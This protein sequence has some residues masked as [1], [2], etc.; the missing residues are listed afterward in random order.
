M[1]NLIKRHP[2]LAYSLF[3]F[4]V[5]WPIY[6]LLVAVRHGWMDAPIPYW[7]HYLASFGPTVGALVVTAS[8]AGGQGLKELWSRMIKWRVG[9]GYAIFAVFS[10]IALFI[11]ALLI[12]RIVKGEWLDLRLLGQAN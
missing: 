7:I 1:F 4:A 2:I 6:F 5:S 12:V 3:T 8:T 9:W 11:L 10:P